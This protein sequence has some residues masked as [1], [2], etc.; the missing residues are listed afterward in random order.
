MC[1]VH[2]IR[3]L[4]HFVS[5]RDNKMFL[6]MSVN[7]KW[8]DI[9]EECLHFQYCKKY[10]PERIVLTLP[11]RQPSNLLQGYD[12]VTAPAILTEDDYKKMVE[13]VDEI[14]LQFQDLFG[15]HDTRGGSYLELD[16]I[17]NVDNN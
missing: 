12:V 9:L 6:H 5:L 14:V 13:E 1:V 10:A 11:L 2:T 7:T 16:D 4:L 15:K 3:M 8:E 17:D